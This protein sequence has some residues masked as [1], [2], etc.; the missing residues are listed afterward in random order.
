M[1]NGHGNC[2]FAV[3]CPPGSEAQTEALAGEMAK[4]L[5]FLHPASLRETAAWVLKT[6]DLAPAGTLQSFKDAIR[7]YAREPANG[8]AAGEA[9]AYVGELRADPAPA[10]HVHIHLDGG[11]ES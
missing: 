8:C 4:A 10:L 5:P 2:I 9:L 6:Y 1:A 11:S 3:C 7:D